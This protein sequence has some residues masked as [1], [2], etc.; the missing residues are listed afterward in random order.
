MGLGCLL[1]QENSKVTHLPNA[2]KNIVNGLNLF[3]LVSYCDVR[4]QSNPFYIEG[5]RRVLVERAW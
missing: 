3:D 2:S 5:D 4:V 1:R